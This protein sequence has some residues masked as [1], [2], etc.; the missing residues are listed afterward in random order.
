[1]E[2]TT[3]LT[4]AVLGAESTGKT[5][6]AKA[7][8]EQ[9]GACTGLATTWVPESLRAWC[10]REGRT[11]RADEQA[12]IA[13]LQREAIE[14]AARQHPIVVCDTTPLMTAVYSRLLFAD[15]SLDAA[16]LAFQHRCSLTLV[17]AL[18]LPWQADGWMRDGPQV[19]TPVDDLLR[20]LLHEHAVP[21][22]AVGGR[23]TV[24]L[25]R[26]LAAAMPLLRRHGL[27]VRNDGLFTRLQTRGRD[28]DSS[29]AASAAPWC[30]LCDDADCEH[31]S[32]RAR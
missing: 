8:A 24:R 5:T 26:A 21:W 32:R 1:M 29:S 12:G 17:T 31:R 22:S 18:D 9:L 15:A 7:L 23:D 16:A 13:A 10:E 14:A 19:R 2:G 30:Q 27:P 4:I 28:A 11:P 25:D 3:A 20:R 6:L